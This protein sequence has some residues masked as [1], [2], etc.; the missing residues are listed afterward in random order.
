MSEM[1]KTKVRAVGTSLGVLLPK[2]IVKNEK[3]HE[4]EQIEIMILKEKKLQLID[5]A[6]GSARGAKPFKRENKDRLDGYVT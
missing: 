2:E 4:G 3:L 1:F 6:F 5:E